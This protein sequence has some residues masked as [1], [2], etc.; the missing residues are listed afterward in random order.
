MIKSIFTRVV[1]VACLS[2]FA[3]S[4]FAEEVALIRQDCEEEVAGYGIESS[5][6]QAKAV[7]DCVAMRSGSGAQE[8]SND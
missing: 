3:V 4:A 7:A 6:E 8:E 2:G 1:F 5:E